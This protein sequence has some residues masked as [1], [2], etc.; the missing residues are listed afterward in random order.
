MKNANVLVIEDDAFKQELIERF[1]DHAGHV[2]TRKAVTRGEALEAVD[3]IAA[4]DLPCDVVILDG[5]LGNGKPLDVDDARAVFSGIREYELGVKV[6]GYSGGDPLSERGLSVD[7]DVRKEDTSQLA[8]VI[9]G[10]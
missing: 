4:G 2:V 7:V 1:L 5:N 9:D 3:D 8:G 6:I 10:L